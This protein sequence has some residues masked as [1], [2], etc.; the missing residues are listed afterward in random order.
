MATFCRFK[1]WVFY[2]HCNLYCLKF[3]SW[4]LL[5]KQEIVL[6]FYDMAELLIPPLR[7]M[8]YQYIMKFN[9]LDILLTH[10]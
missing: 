2:N 6:R 5:P 1:I 8:K 3:N 7:I 9:K 10:C 4:M